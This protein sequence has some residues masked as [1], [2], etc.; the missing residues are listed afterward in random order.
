MISR[1]MNFWIYSKNLIQLWCNIFQ[2][3]CLN[4][5]SKII[6]EKLRKLKTRSFREIFFSVPLTFTNRKDVQCAESHKFSLTETKIKTFVKTAFSITYSLP[7]SDG[8]EWMNEKLFCENRK[9]FKIQFGGSYRFQSTETSR[10]YPVW[11]TNSIKTNS[12]SCDNWLIVQIN[13]KRRAC[14]EEWNLRGLLDRRLVVN[15]KVNVKST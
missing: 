2:K 15:G 13:F 7:V 3:T 4:S 14:L 6:L 10:K 12:I 9:S 1:N 5:F 11:T 8:I